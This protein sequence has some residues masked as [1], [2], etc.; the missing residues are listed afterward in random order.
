MKKNVENRDRQ[1]QIEG[2][3]FAPDFFKARQVRKERLTIP[4]SIRRLKRCRQLLTS[5]HQK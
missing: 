3:I 5:V 4:A 2:T 1:I